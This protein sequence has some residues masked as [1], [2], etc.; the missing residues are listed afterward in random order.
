MA[1]HREIAR[2]ALD[3]FTTGHLDV[4]DQV[5]AADCVMHDSQI[6]LA[7]DHRGPE[8]ARWQV[9]TYRAVFPDLEMTVEDQ[10]EDGDVV[11]SRWSATGT[12]NGDMPMQPA[13]GQSVTVTGILIERFKDDQI[14]EI[15]SNW[16]ALGML[17]QLAAVPV[18]GDASAT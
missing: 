8:V 7:A 18:G 4:L 17:Q 2:S 16:D 12:Q 11:V 1:G 6:P 3:A 9:M 13:T 14:V 5:I 15:W 10:Y